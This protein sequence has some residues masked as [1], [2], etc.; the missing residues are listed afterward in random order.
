MQPPS[1]DTS[2]SR[3]CARTF[4]TG[5]MRLMDCSFGADGIVIENFPSGALYS[6]QARLAK[7]TFDFKS[8]GMATKA[9]KAATASAT[10]T[11]TSFFPPAEED[12]AGGGTKF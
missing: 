3:R 10:A 6:V 2:A 7:S 4:P 11:P 8:L 5:V 9:T 12:G 1:R